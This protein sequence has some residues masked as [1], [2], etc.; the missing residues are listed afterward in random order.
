MKTCPATITGQCVELRE[1]NS[2]DPDY[3]VKVDPCPV[4]CVRAYLLPGC[5]LAELVP[6]EPKR[7]EAKA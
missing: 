5:E 6:A 2:R 7:R 4:E 1:L 3:P